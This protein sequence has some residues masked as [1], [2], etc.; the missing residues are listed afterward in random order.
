MGQKAGTSRSPEEARRFE[1]LQAGLSR[2][3]RA[4]QSSDA[5]RTVVIIPSLS[6]DQEVLSRISGAHHYEER[7]LCYLMLL[8][9]PRTRVVYVSSYPIPE[10]IIDY[11]M[12]LLPGIPAQHARARL[13]LLSC[14]DGSPV[15]LTA[16][17]LERP[18][19]LQRIRDAIPDLESAYLTCFNVTELERDLALR[20][21]LPIYG[22]NP[23]LLS[24]GSKS[25]SRKI[26]REAGIAMP[27][28]FEDLFGADEVANALVELKARRPGIKR[29]VVKL[30]EGFSGE[31]NAV[32]AYEGSQ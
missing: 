7:M 20:L 27:E 24:W 10:S 29:A 22:C 19:L 9:L 30:N 8:R 14:H 17:I 28:G 3:F 2:A 32:F 1:D 31:G 11:Y 6:L 13:T 21:D 26:F 18:R 16:K 12:H 25:G 23:D 15:P 4:F 5:P